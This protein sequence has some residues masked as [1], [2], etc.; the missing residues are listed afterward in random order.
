M[1]RF[2]GTIYDETIEGDWVPRKKEERNCTETRRDRR[3][4]QHAHM[5]DML[6]QIM[7]RSSLK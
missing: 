4:E 3:G 6:L 2:P 5:E 1:Q 7:G